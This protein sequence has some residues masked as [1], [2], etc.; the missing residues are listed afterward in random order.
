MAGVSGC[1]KYSMFIFNFL[2]WLSGLLILGIAIWVRVNQG[3]QEIFS[4]E[5]SHAQF[6]VSANIMISVGAIITILG[7]LGCCGAIKESRCMLILFFIG[8]LLILLLQVAAGVIGV[9]FKPEYKRILN[10]TLHQEAKLLSETNDEAVKLQKAVAEL[11]EKFKCCGLI[12]GAADW[13]NNF[14]KYYKSCECPVMSNLS[15]TTYEGKS[16]YK[17]T[18]ISLIKEEFGKYF[19]IVIGI[20]FGLAFIEVLGMIFSMVLFCQIGEK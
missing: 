14:E 15:C 8:L 13:G 1:L 12:N 6:L 20:A 19:I 3:S 10:E 5:D 16:V 7:F 9:I 18:C 17:Q 4:H 2:F 11:E